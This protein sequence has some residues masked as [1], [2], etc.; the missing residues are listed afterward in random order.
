MFDYTSALTEDTRV[1]TIDIDK[2]GDMDYIYLLDGILY[3]KYSWKN[4]PK[5][6]LDTTTKIFSIS[7]SDLVP[8][9]P[10]YFHEN[11]SL[12]KNLNFSFVP[13]NHDETEWRADF[14]DRYIEWDH[15][16]IGDHDPKT[17]PKT[18]ID[19][20]LSEKN[21]PIPNAPIASTHVTRSL[22]SVKDTASFVLQGRRIDIYTGA[23]SISLS[24]GRVLYTGRESVSITYKD[25]TMTGSSQS[26]TL[27]PYTGYE[28]IN[29]TEVVTS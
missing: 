3:V 1:D 10:D 7:P 26:I 5:K 25:T 18:T 13:S 16:D 27:A 15:V 19:M 8:Y 17:T 2:D 28:F 21:S 12:P 29:S 20:F 14:Y 9:T 4:T 6:I 22:D 11:N 24:P 23:L